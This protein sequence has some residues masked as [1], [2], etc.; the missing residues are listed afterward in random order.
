MDKETRV[1]IVAMGTPLIMAIC[2]WINAKA[3]ADKA[4]KK[5]MKMSDSFQEYIEYV[6]EQRGC[7]P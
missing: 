2:G 3:E 4:E 1:L 7:E 6:M 5:T